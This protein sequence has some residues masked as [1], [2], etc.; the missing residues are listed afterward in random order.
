MNVIT[1]CIDIHKI[2]RFELFLKN[3]RC[4]KGY[5]YTSHTVI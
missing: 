4:E 1:E 3:K 2:F 5:T